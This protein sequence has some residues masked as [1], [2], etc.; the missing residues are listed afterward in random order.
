MSHPIEFRPGA[1]RDLRERRDI[2]LEDLADRAQVSA[3]Q[4]RNIENGA[5]V[6]RADTLARIASALH[7]GVQAFFAKRSQ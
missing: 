1:L 2:R 3:R 4:L 7:V 5:G 6:P